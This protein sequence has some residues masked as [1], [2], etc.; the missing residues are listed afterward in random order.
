MSVEV[1]TRR[2]VPATEHERQKWFVLEGYVEGVPAVTKR[3]SIAVTALV[4]RPALLEESRAKLIADV[5]E[6]YE[7]FKLLEDIG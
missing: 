7:N 1:K 2:I 5:T 4:A 6:Y 3:T